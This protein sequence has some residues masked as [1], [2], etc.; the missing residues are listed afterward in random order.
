M[1]LL[2]EEELGDFKR[3]SLCFLGPSSTFL[4]LLD[5]LN[6]LDDKR[7][8]RRYSLIQYRR[9]QGATWSTDLCLKEDWSLFKCIS[10]RDVEKVGERLKGVALGR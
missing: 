10:A 2:L 3:C 1:K 5:F 7:Q 6:L 9:C 8:T 4:P